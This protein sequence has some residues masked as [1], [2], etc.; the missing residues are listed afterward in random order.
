M[1]GTAVEG[2]ELVAERGVHDM[3]VTRTIK[4]PR[5]RVFNAYTDAA[6]IA[7]WWGPRRYTT[8]VDRLEPRAGGSW[9]FI[10]RAGEDQEFGFHGVFHDV[11]QDSRIVWTFEFEGMPGHVS[12]ETV[13][14]E[15]AGDAT[16][17]RIHSVF[18]SVADRDGAL[19][20]GMESGIAESFDRLE[21][22]LASG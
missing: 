21:Q 14:F 1:G 18:E 13:S 10:N 12:L 6:A 16:T 4:A 2:L 15:D 17:I 22:L 11:V 8:I 19:Q 20:S 5:A 9:R 3:F 7:N